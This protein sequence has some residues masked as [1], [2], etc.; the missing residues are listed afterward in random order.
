VLTPVR[1]SVRFA[2]CG[3][4]ILRLACLVLLF[5]PI[6]VAQTNNPKHIMILMQ[7]DISWPAYRLI[8]ENARSTL[9]AGFS[10]EVV[11]FSEHLDRVYFPDP[12]FQAQQAAGIQR[13]YA[14][15][16]LDLVIGVGDVPTDLFPGGP[17]LYVRTDP[18][19]KRPSAPA[20][21]KDIVN[22]WIELDARK[23]LDAARQLQPKA[24]QIV[25]IGSTSTTGRNFLAQVRNQIGVES[26][27]LPIAYLENATFDE[28]CQKVSALGPES[29]VLFVSLSRDGNG[30]AFISAETIP[31]ISSVSGAPVYGLLDTHIGSGAMGGYVV[32]FAEMG[33]RAGELGLQMLAGGH[34]ADEVAQSDYLFDWRQ[35]RRWKIPESAL[36]GGSVIL[37][38][39]PS[40][41]ESHKS[42]ILAAILLCVLEAFLI[43]G[44]LWQRRNRRKFEQSLLGRVAF[45]KMLSDLSATFINLPEEQVGTTIEKSLGGI[46][47]FL[48]LDTVTL[49][50]YSKESKDLQVAFS[51]RGQ[52]V[53]NPPVILR[54]NQLPWW[55]ALLLRGE[56]LLVS[57][58][59][60]L[61]EE[62]FAEKEYLAGIGAVSLAII[63]LK[64]GDELFGGITFLTTRRRVVWTDALVEQLK[65]LAEIFSNALARKCALDARYR[66]AAIVES[67]DDAII[68]K[69]LDGIIV[70]WN[71]AAQRLYGYSA[72]EAIGKSTAMLIPHEQQDEEAEFL[73]RLEAGQ[74]V[75]HHETVRIAKGGRRVAVSLTISRVK[76]SAGKVV[77]FSKIARDI[78]DRKRAEQVL[79][80]SEERFRLVANSAPVLIWMSG[81]DKLCTFLNQNWLN[82][83]GRQMED[84]LG[85]GWVSSVHPDDVQRYI[86]LYSACFNAR[87]D[88]EMEYRLRRFDGEYRWIADFGVPRFESDGTFCGY[89]GSCVDITERKSA[90]ESLQALTGRLI[91]VQEEE[92]ARIARELHDDFNQRL[93][94]QCI[95][96]E[97]LRRRLPEVQVGERASL[98]RIVQR[99]KA[100]SADLRSLSHELHSSRLDFIGLV[101]AVSGLCKEI[102]KKY[103]M[104]V[105]FSGCELP[106]NIP[107]DVTL[108]LFRVAQEALSN[109]AKHSQANRASVELGHSAN[110]VSLRITDKGSGFDLS[111]TNRGFGLGLIGMTERLRLVGGRLSVRS[112]L[113]RGTEILAEVPLPAAVNHQRVKAFVTGGR[114]S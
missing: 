11:V 3:A 80:E 76:D 2:S 8:G 67:S 98:A 57:D 40:L 90:A 28:I 106:V 29:I 32:R 93:A 15:S 36:P 111:G 1:H 45:E 44:L 50:S 7:E 74:R 62:A 59:T 51:W 75:E 42:L 60:A 31:R 26:N 89:I 78:S 6:G 27:G 105:Q 99:T 85:E 20:S 72:A 22:L 68:S 43:L 102:G 97:Q 56:T 108:C 21:S 110:G 114:K 41:W 96:L 73:R 33:R 79:R 107:K 17:F 58:F 52:G 81:T 49:Y 10:G 5:L 113:K 16:K 84:E 61:P 46:A 12:Q 35:L 19:Q 69:N 104:A 103:T 13:K 39:Q 83:T 70:S 88:F 101:P 4:A 92:R 66:H 30:R 37:F 65:L 82:F 91:H 18:S 34:P 87:L 86:E 38:R 64:A 48:K 95:E 54:M 94:L 23:T 71:A 77:G 14:N 63:P 112:E 109:V 55:C 100:M 47:E 9:R 53:D 24:S 25:V